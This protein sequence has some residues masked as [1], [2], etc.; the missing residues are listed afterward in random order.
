M[1]IARSSLPPGNA[2]IEKCR[3]AVVFDNIGPYHRARLEAAAG[4][5]DL[6]AIELGKTSS[7]Y[8]WPADEKQSFRRVTI[9]P[10]GESR[11]L[12]S[13]LLRERLRQALGDFN[14]DVVFLPGWS[15]RGSIFAMQ[16]CVQNRKRAVVM[17]EST[18][19][20]SGRRP[21]REFV[22]R[23]FVRLSAA[24]F[25]GGTPQRDY[26]IKL[27]IEPER[28][29]NGY[30][31]VDNGHFETGAASIRSAETE[32]GRLNQ[33]SEARRQHQLPGRYFLASARFIEK[34]NL[35]RLIAAYARYRSLARGSGET[36]GHEIWD[37]VLLGD[38]P[39]RAALRSQ[40]AALGLQGCVQLPG[41]Q[42]YERLPVFYGLAEAF[43]HASATEQWG[44]VVN[45]AL[46]SGLPVIVSN[47]CGCVFDLVWNGSN[48]FV[49]DPYDVEQLARLMLRV[50][51]MDRGERDRMGDVSRKIVADWGPDRFARGLKEAIGCAMGVAPV[52]ASL[53]DRLLLRLL[54]LR[55]SHESLGVGHIRSA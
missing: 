46:A 6:L 5:C 53:L 14:A 26:L 27:G 4:A 7:E 31:A 17:S 52:R 10:L 47:R 51:K 16:W 29:A 20:D 12:G 30:D 38:G 48:G 49:F 3:T 8:C 34:K 37:L 11:A 32:N 9:N 54:V 50:A 1:K 43:V 42:S 2:S 36:T 15:C 39:L 13:S 33:I 40:V 23:R 55:E 45:E 18:F 25:A 24:G 41:F 28:V 19:R 22:K 44:L 35:S 21:L